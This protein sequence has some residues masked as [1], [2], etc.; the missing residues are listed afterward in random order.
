MQATHLVLLPGLDGTGLLF[1]PLVEALPNHIIPVV[2]SYPKNQPLGYDDLLVLILTQLPKNSPYVVLGE[3]FSGPL[4]LRIATL[5]PQG[6]QGVILNA[7]FITH[8]H[9]YIPRWIKH[10]IPCF[11]YKTLPS[12]AKI[13]AYFGAYYSAD[14]HNALT[15]VSPQVFAHRLQEILTVDVTAELIKCQLPILY[16]QAKYD[17]IVPAS[18]LEHILKLKPTVQHIQIDA[19]HLVLQSQPLL[20]M[21][22]ISAFIKVCTH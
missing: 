13:G 15:S 20:A 22:A 14:M 2:I 8:P 6:L 16:I 21:Q 18:N 12:L 5:Q 19:P 17:G 7:T 1:K 10:L 11:P 3:S 4:A 9:H